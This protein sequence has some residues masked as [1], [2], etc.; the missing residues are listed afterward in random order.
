MEGHSTALIV[1]PLFSYCVLRLM[2]YVLLLPCAGKTE[3]CPLRTASCVKI[4]SAFCVQDGIGTSTPHV[5]VQKFQL[6]FSKR[7]LCF[8]DFLLGEFW[9]SKVGAGICQHLCLYPSGCALRTAHTCSLFPPPSFC[10]RLWPARAVEG[11]PARLPPGVPDPPA[12]RPTPWPCVTPGSA[13][14]VSF[15]WTPAARHPRSPA[16]APLGLHQL[17]FP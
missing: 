12:R 7:F 11:S 1:L 3:R 6:L 5:C 8:T 9:Y 10:P 16:N 17:S 13:H 4:K 2:G 14:A 15:P